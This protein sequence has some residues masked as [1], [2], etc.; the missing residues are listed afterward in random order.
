MT[1]KEVY[2][3]YAPKGAKWVEWV[4]PVSFIAIDKYN[5]VFLRFVKQ[6]RIVFIIPI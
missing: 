1:G 4:R 6:K 3:I 5:I 2:K